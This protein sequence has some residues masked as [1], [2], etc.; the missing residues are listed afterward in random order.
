MATALRPLYAALLVLSGSASISGNLLLLLVLLLNRE[1]WSDTPTFT[2]SA[3]LS[4]LA[5][6]ISTIPFAVHNTLSGPVE[7]SSEGALCQGS[8]FIFLLLQTSSIQ[9]L[10]WVTVDK[11]SEICFALSYRSVWTVRRSRSALVLLWLFSAVNAALPLVGFGKYHYSEPRALCCPDFAPS[12]RYFVALW[13]TFGIAVPIVFMCFLH[14]CIV[15]VARKQA[16]RGTFI[17]NELHCFHVPANNYLKSSM[18][19]VTSSGETA[20]FVIT[21]APDGMKVEKIK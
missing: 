12:S 11:F 9:S 20:S 19:M 7:F 18:V 17:C 10:T 13:A 15:C 3:G 2:L 5:L 6:A 21:S 16:R 1:L 14:G 8:G 4:D